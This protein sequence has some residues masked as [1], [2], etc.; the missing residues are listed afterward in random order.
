MGLIRPLNQMEETNTTISITNGKSLA[1]SSHKD[2]K[3]LLAASSFPHIR[4]ARLR[5]QLQHPVSRSKQTSIGNKNK[6]K[7]DSTKVNQMFAPQSA[8]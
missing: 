2:E 6:T 1:G 8:N 3:R 4:Q 7:C 5:L